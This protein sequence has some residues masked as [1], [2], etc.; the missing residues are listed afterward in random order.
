MSKSNLEAIKIGFAYVGVIV[1]AGFST[2]QEV[3][4]FFTNYGMYSYLAIIISGL[5]LTFFGRQTVKLGYGLD[6]ENHESTIQYLFGEKFGKLIDYLLVFFLYG[7]STI[8]IA[9]AGSAAHESFGI[10]VWLGSLLMVIAI[11][12][13]LLLDFN[14]IVGAL[15][16]VTP[17]LIIV[18]TTIAIYYFFKGSIPF[19]EVQDHINPDKQP[20]KA[21]FLPE[22]A[23]WWWSGLNYGGLAFASG[24][25]ILAAIGGDSS[26]MKIAGRGATIGG[27][28]LLVLLAMVNSGLL[29]ELDQINNSAIPTLILG[30]SIHPFIGIALSIIMLMVIYNTIA[31]LMYSFIAR[32][33]EPYST[34]YKVM[35]FGLMGLSYV[36]SFVGFSKLVQFAY[37][38]LG[39]V[40]LILCIGITI[41]YFKRKNRGKNHIV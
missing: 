20:F 10:P 9:G 18:V 32:F 4:T 16:M 7:L 21:S 26:R 5:M 15:G 38:L 29:S 40:G 1:G 3:L 11:I 19:N 30:K 25:S 17:F 31:G 39:Y 36:L 22:S 28:I 23:L 33:S 24:F 27:F 34:K 8:M 37:P 13:T 41:K 35:L 14:K 2:G 12:I 6:A